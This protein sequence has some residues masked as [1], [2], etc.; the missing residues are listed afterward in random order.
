MTDQIDIH[1]VCAP[2]F[3][4]VREAFAANF[5]AAP[6]GLD[7]QAARFSVLVEGEAVVDLWAGYADTAR[8][9]PFTD[10][11]LTPVFSTGKAV[12]AILMAT[13]VEA[14]QVDYDQPVADLAAVGRLVSVQHGLPPLL[15]GLD[16]AAD[17]R[18]VLAAND[19]VG[20]RPVVVDRAEFAF[21]VLFQ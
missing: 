17:V 4:A 16:Q 18:G 13:A 11:A 21:E 20:Q 14:G 19:R 9:T 6:E 10:M 15:D 3:E 5:T 2:G 7:E 8:T 12:M 1:G